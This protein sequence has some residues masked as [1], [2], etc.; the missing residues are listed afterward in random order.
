MA[1]WEY[2]TVTLR[3]TQGQDKQAGYFARSQTIRAIHPDSERELNDLGR[4]GWEM[5]SVML[6]DLGSVESGPSTATAFLKRP[7]E[8]T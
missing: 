3:V 1:H 5:V 7:F 2:R 8:M 6:L 4:Q